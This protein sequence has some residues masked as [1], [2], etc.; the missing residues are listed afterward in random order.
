MV[1]VNG[2]WALLVI[3]TAAEPQALEGVPRRHDGASEPSSNGPVRRAQH[4]GTRAQLLSQ[5]LRKASQ[6]GAATVQ[7]HISQ[8][9]LLLLGLQPADTEEG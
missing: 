6:Q 2:P 4:G 8:Q 3:L 7:H 9:L 1:L 5:A